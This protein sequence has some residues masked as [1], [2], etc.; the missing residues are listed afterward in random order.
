MTLA[1]KIFIH[2]FVLQH[3]TLGDVLVCIHGGVYDVFYIHGGAVRHSVRR[4]RGQG[5]GGDQRRPIT[6]RYWV[7]RDRDQSTERQQPSL[8]RQRLQSRECQSL[9]CRLDSR[10]LRRATSTQIGIF[11]LLTYKPT[12]TYLSTLVHPVTCTLGGADSPYKISTK[13]AEFKKILC[14]LP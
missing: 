11:N 5:C 7:S 14:W 4:R 12:L 10:S 1:N 9:C 8:G 2:L 6:E 13:I 3:L